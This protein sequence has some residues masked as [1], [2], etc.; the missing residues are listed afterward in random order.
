[1]NATHYRINDEAAA[2]LLASFPSAT[3]ESTITMDQAIT[4]LKAPRIN[5]VWPGQGGIYMG[6]ARGLDGQPDAHLILA[7]DIPEND[8]SINW[9]AAGEWAKGLSVDGH[10]DFSLPTR[11][12][13][14]LL[15]ANG[16]DRFMTDDWYWT[17]SEY[18]ERLAWIQD[19]YY[20]YQLDDDK[21]HEARARAV[22]LIH[23]DA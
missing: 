1:M 21:S 8:G 9:A 3:A 15:Y 2:R 17:S 4:A 16:A 14:A 20:G 10:S 12:Q 19:F 13:A 11:S 18:S 23:I 22:R 7:A 5:T 6:I